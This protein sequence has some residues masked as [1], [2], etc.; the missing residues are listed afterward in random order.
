MPLYSAAK[1]LLPT[2]VKTLALELAASRQRC[3][4]VVFDVVD[5][6]MNAAMAARTRLGHEDRSPFGTLISP[7]AAA[8]QI[9]WLLG[10]SSTFLSGAMIDLSGGA[11]P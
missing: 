9:E 3:F 10:N 5:G 8:G 2:L 7:D 4:G 6:G 1:S 11:L